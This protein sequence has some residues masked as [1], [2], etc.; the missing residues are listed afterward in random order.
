MS[1]KLRVFSL[2]VVFSMLS[3]VPAFG[4]DQSSPQNGAGEAKGSASLGQASFFGPARDVV[5]SDLPLAPAY[6]GKPRAMPDQKEMMDE[7]RGRATGIP[8]R[9]YVPGKPTDPPQP[10]LSQTPG[11][12][13]GFVGGNEENCFG[14]IPS[15]QALAA[16]S[17]YEVQVINSCLYIYN[18]SGT[19]LHGPVLLNT[20]FGAPNGD[21]VGDPRALYDW[22]NSRFIV[23]CED[24]TANTFVIAASKNS[25]PTGGWWL[26]TL[27]ASGGIAD[28]PMVGQTVQE[29]GNGSAGGLYLS[30]DRFNSST[31]NFQ[32][33]VVWIL[34]KDKIYSGAGFSYYYFYN[35]NFGGSTV[36]HVQPAEVMNR[37]D[38]PRAEF[39]V[40]TKDFNQDC[41]SNSPCNGLDIWSIYYG[42]PPAGG[43]PTLT[44]IHIG[45]ANNYIYP[46]TSAQPGAASGTECAIHSGY[47]GISST[48]YWSAGDLYATTT[49][50]AL[51]GDAS[52][53]FLYWQVHPYLTNASPSTMSGASIRNEV[54]YGCNGIADGTGS[55]Y[56][57]AVQP[58]EEG[59][60]TIVFNYS[61]DS[62]YPST[63]WLSNRTTEA[64]GTFEDTGFFLAEGD[65]F[66]C[67]IDGVG[68]NRWGDYTAGAPYG[69][70]RGLRPTFWF[71]GQWS[72]EDSDWGTYIGQNAFTAPAQP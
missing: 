32:D 51:N 40:D 72:E 70:I 11:L 10:V 41:V 18:N 69:S 58:N 61:S 4:A 16:S 63:A 48:V 25:N 66:Y 2:V 30:W 26:Y 33:D 22:R 60:I 7:E 53:A 13:N 52:D 8:S 37:G 65:A 45:T 14:Y 3:L 5:L 6:H 38:Q 71:A 1:N 46:V 43:S 15:D 49:T 64:E 21:A 12:T 39:L 28:F 50:A 19:I 35:L 54:C 20:F 24:F 57:S 36:D 27:S 29:E 55:A 31:G 47:A 67:Q 56:Y 42:V 34:P 23:V 68:R 44:G 62:V 59:D 9:G 17:N